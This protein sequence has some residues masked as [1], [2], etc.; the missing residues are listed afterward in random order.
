MGVSCSDSQ[1]PEKSNKTYHPWR[2]PKSRIRRAKTP[3]PIATNFCMS[4]AV[5]VVITHANFWKDRLRGFG[6][7]RR[8]VEFW[9]FALTCFVAFTTRSHY[10]TIVS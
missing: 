8:L 4:G 5:Y 10:R 2:T 9:A 3:E 7:A 6:A 1:K